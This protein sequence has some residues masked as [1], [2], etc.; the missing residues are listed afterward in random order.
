M[1]AK[2]Y[3]SLQKLMHPEMWYC[4]RYLKSLC[5]IRKA[6]EDVCSQ[7][8]CRKLNNQLL[9]IITWVDLEDLKH[10]VYEVIESTLKGRVINQGGADQE[11]QN[12]NPQ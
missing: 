12:G 9:S 7:C 1:H 2:T 6:V 11:C 4:V 3:E 10:R 5:E 8:K